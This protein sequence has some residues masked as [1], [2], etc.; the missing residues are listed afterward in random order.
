MR[1]P[2]YSR[3]G[4]LNSDGLVIGGWLRNIL[5]PY[6]MF[7]NQLF[8]I[9]E[10]KGLPMK[11]KKKKPLDNEAWR[12]KIACDGAVQGGEPC[13]KGTRVRVSV[14]VASVAD[15]SMEEVLKD[16]PQLSREDVRAALLYASEASRSHLVA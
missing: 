1:L 4:S 13:I 6:N 2:C 14:I 11:Q 16:Y 10:E 15:T 5:I 8:G 9:E 7:T 3:K 12:K